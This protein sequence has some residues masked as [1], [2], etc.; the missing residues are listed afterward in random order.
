MTPQKTPPLAE[1]LVI[2]ADLRDAVILIVDSEPRPQLGKDN[3]PP[4]TKGIVRKAVVFFWVSAL[5]FMASAV[6]SL[7]CTFS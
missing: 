6:V 4:K 3:D 5:A 2:A 1:Q 7:T